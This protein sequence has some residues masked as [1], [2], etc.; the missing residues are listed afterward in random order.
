M[1]KH[2]VIKFAG[3][4]VLYIAIIIGLFI[5]QFKAESII[6]K[7]IGQM[8]IS[9]V[10]DTAEATDEPK[11]KNQLQLSF[12][13]LTFTANEKEPAAISSE[14]GT[15]RNLV[16][17]S[18]QQPDDN[19]VRFSF[20]DGTTLTFSLSDKGADAGL[21]VT[22]AP[23]AGF[24]TLSIPYAVSSNY[25]ASNETAKSVLLSF[26]NSVYEFNAPLLADGRL[27]F[28]KDAMTASYAAYVPEKV[29][30]FTD[31]FALETEKEKED[32]Y[33][34][35]VNA[36]RERM[37]KEFTRVRTE[38]P[39]KLSEEAITAYV[40]EMG[41][42]G[43]YTAAINAIPSSFKNS[44]T[45]TYLSVPYF[46]NLKAMNQSLAAKTKEFESSIR[47]AL[48][49]KDIDIFCMDGIADYILREKKTQPV[50]SLLDLPG[51]MEGFSPT[52]K[53]AAGILSVYSSIRRADKTLSTRLDKATETCTAAIA[54][55]IRIDEDGAVTFKET[56]DSPSFSSIE[57]IYIGQNLI[58]YGKA[59]NKNEFSDTGRVI[60][61]QELEAT[62]FDLDT[63]AK[64]Y[65]QLVREN[66]YYPHTVILGYYGNSSV[67]AWT[68]ASDISYKLET[69]GTVNMTIDFPLE[70]T[71]YLTVTGVPT[72]HSQIEIQKIRFRSD[73]NFEAYN[74]SGYIYDEDNGTL[75]L[76]S[77][78]K[79]Q[80]ELVRLFC[81]TATNFTNADGSLDLLQAQVR[82]L[83]LSNNVTVRRTD[84]GVTISIEN[85]QF[86]AESATLR[87]TEFAKLEQI[88]RILQTPA[89]SENDIMIAGHSA[90]SN[91]GRPA[92]PLSEERAA[93]V[94]D[95]FV[96][97]GVR[98]RDH[99]ITQGF[100]DTKPIA[101]NDTEE[102][103]SKNR[104]VEI[105]IMNK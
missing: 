14:D 57:K 17:S 45:R 33:T 53:Q 6:S 96:Q 92:Q 34:A 18:W 66:F 25:T 31:I 74:S 104:R 105:T 87:S 26:K 10:Q 76:K 4:S 59:R 19:S 99:I 37:V 22:A 77:R 73:P 21:S 78:H 97:L 69:N 88:A 95:Y 102:N 12:K 36:L 90:K 24:D 49:N 61:N 29:F 16:L 62:D 50:L 84:I 68:C 64:L 32:M 15:S 91:I 47:S 8:K 89:Y 101:P 38:S 46:G 51:S 58:N 71:H 48:E 7:S 60:V 81:D 40:A 43:Q 94:A 63:M 52:I 72:F 1:R 103:R 41:S 86:E 23:A 100:G 20:S 28:T 65:P 30:E 2:P 67:W 79:S 80:L 82:D 11:L 56:E 70:R 75:F 13:G 85:I 39:E 42:Q 35:N 83:G 9:L 93:A 55:Y 3:L 5:T 27:V 44:K 98:T 54:Q